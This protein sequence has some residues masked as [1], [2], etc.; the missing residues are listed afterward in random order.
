M[1]IVGTCNMHEGKQEVYISL[2][3][4]IGKKDKVFPMI[5]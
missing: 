5:N 3:E 1:E 4:E 2:T